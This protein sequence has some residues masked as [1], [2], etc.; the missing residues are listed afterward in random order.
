MC[1]HWFDWRKQKFVTAHNL[2][3]FYHSWLRIYVKATNLLVD[4]LSTIICRFSLSRSIS[5]LA[6]KSLLDLH[7]MIT[8]AWAYKKEKPHKMAQMWWS[9]H[10]IGAM[11]ACYFTCQNTIEF[12]MGSPLA[13]SN[14][15]VLFYAWESISCFCHAFS[16]EHL[17]YSWTILLNLLRGVAGLYLSRSDLLKGALNLASEKLCLFLNRMTNVQGTLLCMFTYWLKTFEH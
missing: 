12:L 3:L 2:W 13:M 7:K 16:K 14:S 5:R 1:L 4:C 6:L 11:S 8:I 15:I 9:L 10:L 17:S